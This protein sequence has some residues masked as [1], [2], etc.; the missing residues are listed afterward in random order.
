MNRDMLSRRLKRKGYEVV[1]AVDGRLGVSMAQTEAPD[2]ILMD[3][4]MEEMNGFEACEKIKNDFST[5]FIPVI[6]LTSQD[7]VQNKV[8]GLGSWGYEVSVAASG[9]EAVE[10]EL[11]RKYLI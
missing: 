11:K 2:L 4:N 6:M 1:I 10:R 7:Q 5:A 3:V 8:H 9:R